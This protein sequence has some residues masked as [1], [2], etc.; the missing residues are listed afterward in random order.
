M[1]ARESMITD[2]LHA[3]HRGQESPSEVTQIGSELLYLS[4]LSGM[5]VQVHDSM[6]RSDRASVRWTVFGRHDKEFLGMAPTNREVRF[7]GATITYMDKD[8]ITQ[9]AH[10]WDMVALL[11]QIQ[12]Q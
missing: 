5:Q 10:Y 11:Q 12:A 4:A 3:I 8:G 2:R 7:G 6:S 9:E 1:E